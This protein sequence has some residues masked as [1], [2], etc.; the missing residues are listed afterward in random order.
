VAKHLDRLPFVVECP[1]APHCLVSHHDFGFL[2]RVFT[3][4]E[5][6]PRLINDV[7]R[8]NG[9]HELPLKPGGAFLT[10]SERPAE[11]GQL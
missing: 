4:S 1:F 6:L 10:L 2:C 5:D 3:L 11:M 8:D 7:Y 9:L